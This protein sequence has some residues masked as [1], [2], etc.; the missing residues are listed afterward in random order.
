MAPTESSR[1]GF[2]RDIDTDSDGQASGDAQLHSWRTIT[3]I[4]AS[5]CGEDEQLWVWGSALTPHFTFDEWSDPRSQRN[6]VSIERR[7]YGA[8]CKCVLGILSEVCMC[9]PETAQPQT[10]YSNANKV[11]QH[12]KR[13][14]IS[15]KRCV[16][17]GHNPHSVQSP[18]TVMF[19]LSRAVCMSLE[20]DRPGTMRNSHTNT[21][22][23]TLGG[24][25][26]GGGGCLFGSWLVWCVNPRWSF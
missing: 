14:H 23:N 2:W 12:T 9:P 26:G 24:G 21:H 16:E 15:Y 4:T 19:C 3:S 6:S 17:S 1:F 5:D 8:R 22:L 7:R 25:G 18:Y 13:L 11:S 20:W 10:E